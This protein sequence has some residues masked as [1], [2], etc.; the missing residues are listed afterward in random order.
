ME[1]G[2]DCPE[3]E[4]QCGI[5]LMDASLTIDLPAYLYVAESGPPLFTDDELPNAD[6]ET[7]KG[8]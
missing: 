8:V 3:T 2:F 4:V 6:D 7:L 1:R 5:G